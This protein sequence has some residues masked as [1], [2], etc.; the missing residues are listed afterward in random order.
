MGPGTY[1]WTTR[2]LAEFW[3]IGDDVLIPGELFDMAYATPHVEGT[4]AIGIDLAPYGSDENIIAVR[5]GNALVSLKAY[6]AMRTDLFFEGPVADEVRRVDPHY[7][8]WDADGVGAGAYGYADKIAAQHNAREGHNMVLLPF[9]GGIAVDTRYNNARSAWWWALRRRFENHQIAL[10]IP[11]DQKLRDQVTD[12]RYEVTDK[13]DIKVE[14]KKHM[15]TRGRESPDRGDGLMYAFSMVE[16]LPIPTLVTE[17]PIADLAGVKDRSAEAMWKRDMANLRRGRSQR[18]PWA[19][20]APG[21]VWDD[22][23]AWED[24]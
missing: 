14:T 8:I 7:L 1:E 18:T 16:E 24:G 19:R 13:G 2:V 20:T 9:R 6:P 4:R 10:A 5:D 21:G 3:T 11:T 23:D 22:V 17:S 12:I 15:K